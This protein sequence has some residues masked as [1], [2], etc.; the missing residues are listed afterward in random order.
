MGDET[1]IYSKD[2][3]IERITR[4]IY[5]MSDKG[6]EEF[7]RDNFGGVNHRIVDGEIHF[8]WE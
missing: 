3:I 8:E 7:C 5:Q 2:D 1:Q 4:Q 6:L